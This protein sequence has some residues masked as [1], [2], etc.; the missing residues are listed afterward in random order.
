MEILQTSLARLADNKRQVTTVAAISVATWVVFSKI[1]DIYFG[2][3][4]HIPGP[5]W[6]KVFGL[7]TC[8]KDDPPGTTWKEFLKWQDKYGPIVRLGPKYVSISDKALMREVL[9]TQDLHKGPAYNRLRFIEGNPGSL[10]S[11]EDKAFHKQRRRIVSPAFSVKYINSLEPLMAKVIENFIDRIDRDIAKTQENKDKFGIVDLWHVFVLMSLDVI[12]ETA[13]GQTFH[14]LEDSDH[15]VPHTIHKNLEIM[16][17]LVAHPVKGLISFLLDSAN[18]MRANNKLQ[19]FMRK[20]IYDRLNGGESVRR[21]DILQ[22]L[23]DSQKSVHKEDRLT[24]DAIAQ[25]TVLFLIVGSETTSATLGFI[26]IQLL[27]NPDKLALLREEIDALP[28]QGKTFAHEQLK[29]LPYLNGVIHE[30]LRMDPI[31]AVGVERQTYKDTTLGG[32]LFLP[33][34]TAVLCN[35][36]HVHHNPQYWP[37]P[38]KFKPERWLPDAEP[39]A[40]MDAFF[41]FS[42]GSRNCIGKL[43]AMV[44]MRLCISMLVKLYDL[45]AIPEELEQA[46]DK[47][48]F[49][50]LG[51]NSNSVKVRVKRRQL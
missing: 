14:A 15:F 30:G 31:V 40:D 9:V 41:G 27:R 24:V 26:L 32:Q 45:E 13:Y 51:I 38:H 22:I 5:F 12:G 18:I 1:Y 36:N 10:V 50:T 19:Q 35:V 42:A 44:E 21:Q 49:M 39:P 43:Y 17:Y 33:K 8:L 46:E 4:S 7:R 11:A 6:F 16:N 29:N 3:L 2:P 25:E 23:I 37:E 34:G 47:R 28:L 20:I 48:A